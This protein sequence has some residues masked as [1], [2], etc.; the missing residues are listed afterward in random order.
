[1][2]L[3]HRYSIIATYFAM[4]GR[5]W[6]TITIE[7][8]KESAK[9]FWPRSDHWTLYYINDSARLLSFVT[10]VRFRS[11]N[12]ECRAWSRFS[13]LSIEFRC[14][15][16]QLHRWY[17]RTVHAAAYSST[18]PTKLILPPPFLTVVAPVITLFIIS[19]L[20]RWRFQQDDG[21]FIVG[22][23]ASL[24]RLYFHPF[25]ASGDGILCLTEY[26]LPTGNRHLCGRHHLNPLE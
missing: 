25:R 19:P 6:W 3:A 26:R 11:I 24:G 23:T 12:V 16:F 21:Q 15:S 7:G 1:M 9:M 20:P 17:E 10:N 18:I 13:G 14:Y 4:A 8:D 22:I 2:G 5:L